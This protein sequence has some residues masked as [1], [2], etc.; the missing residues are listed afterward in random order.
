[1]YPS[2]LTKPTSTGLPCRWPETGSRHYLRKRTKSPWLARWSQVTT[3]FTET[4]LGRENHVSYIIAAAARPARVPVTAMVRA[5]HR[6][7]LGETKPSVTAV[8]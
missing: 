2:H 4:I 8:L 5:S 6:E 3:E 1:M 7:V